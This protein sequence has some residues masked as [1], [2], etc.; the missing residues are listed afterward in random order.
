MHYLPDSIV[1]SRLSPGPELRA[2]AA[3]LRDD[4]ALPMG[5]QVR[6]NFGGFGDVL[7]VVE[8]HI[9]YGDGRPSSGVPHRSIGLYYPDAT[10][11]TTPDPHAPLVA[12]PVGIDVSGWSPSAPWPVLRDNGIS[13]AF[14][15]AT[16]GATETSGSLREQ[17]AGCDAAGL[18]QGAYHFFRSS[19]STPEAQAEH[20][21]RIAETLSAPEL[22]WG[23]DVESQTTREG[24]TADDQLGH[25]V[26]AVFGDRLLRWEELVRAGG[27]DLRW[28]YTAEGFARLL[29]PEHLA[30]LHR[31]GLALWQAAYGRTTTPSPIAPWPAWSIWQWT[32]TGT[33]T[34]YP[35]AANAC[36]LNRSALPLDELVRA[37]ART[38]PPAPEAEERVSPSGR[39]LDVYDLAN[40]PT[41]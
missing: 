36:D 1:Q 4:H 9:A 24:A 8:L 19:S 13:F 6:R 14:C 41:E 26:P 27:L 29:I 17:W 37:G 10:S 35:A 23:V 18:V 38:A 32:A 15:K 2:W 7:A 5:G 21:L 12:L 33:L 28:L 25:V 31:R 16:E 22:G 3:A 34:G 20:V 39:R 30:E 40:R 11:E